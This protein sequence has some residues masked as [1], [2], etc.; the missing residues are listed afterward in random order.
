MGQATIALTK[1]GL[2]VISMGAIAALNS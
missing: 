2:A 1:L